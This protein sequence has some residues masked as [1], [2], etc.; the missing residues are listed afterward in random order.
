M[1]VVTLASMMTAEEVV[2]A[3]DVTMTVVVADERDETLTVPETAVTVT[4]TV[5]VM[6]GIGMMTG[7]RCVRMF[8]LAAAKRSWISML[9]YDLL[10]FRVLQ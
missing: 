4:V 9:F 7:G 3:V 5:V 6:V 2:G 8:S 1:T 10:L